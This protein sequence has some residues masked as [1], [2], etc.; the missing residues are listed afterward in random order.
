MMYVAFIHSNEDSGYGVSF[1]DFPGC[2]A[3]DDDFNSAL[4][5]AR[6]AL[7]FHVEGMISDGIAIPEPSPA[8]QILSDDSLHEW[9]NGAILTLVPLILDEGSPKRVNISIDRGLLKAIDASASRRGMTR[10]ALI[11]SA[12][13][14]EIA[15]DWETYGAE[16]GKTKLTSVA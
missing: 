7:A 5:Q 16:A 13:R 12:A 6:A 10:S 3:Y 2:V 8:D 11:S 15:G 9:R 14:K 1:P 4:E